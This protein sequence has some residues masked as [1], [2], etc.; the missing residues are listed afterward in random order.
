MSNLSENLQTMTRETTGKLAKFRQMVEQSKFDIAYQPIVY[1]ETEVIHHFEAL[2]RFGKRL[3]RSPYELIRF[4]EDTG[5]IAEFD[6]ATVQRVLN[7]LVQEISRGMMRIVAVNVSGQSI[8][9]PVKQVKQ[10]KQ[11]FIDFTV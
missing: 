5:V 10:V 8:G 3:D 9:A 11:Y 4:A 2:A 6:L 1:L 7:W